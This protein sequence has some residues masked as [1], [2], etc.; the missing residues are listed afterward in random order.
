MLNPIFIIC[1]LSIFLTGCKSLEKPS[2]ISAGK[3][4]SNEKDCRTILTS[5]EE[6]DLVRYASQLSR[7]VFEQG[8][9]PDK[10]NNLLSGRLNQYSGLKR[11]A[12]KLS[13]AKGQE[14][15]ASSYVLSLV[16]SGRSPTDRDKRAL[17]AMNISSEQ[18]ESY[19]GA[20]SGIVRPHLN[21]F[22]DAGYKFDEQL[23]WRFFS[24]DQGIL[25][26]DFEE[27]SKNTRLLASFY[28]FFGPSI[29]S[30][31]LDPDRAASMTIDRYVFSPFH[32]GKMTVRPK[33]KWNSQVKWKLDFFEKESESFVK[34]AKAVGSYS[35]LMTGRLIELFGGERGYQG[36]TGVEISLESNYQKLR[37]VVNSLVFD[38]GVHED[39][40]VT[41]RLCLQALN[42]FELKQLKNGEKKLVAAQRAAVASFFVP[43][44]VWVSPYVAGFS[45][46]NAAASVAAATSAKLALLPMAFGLGSGAISAG[47]RAA[48]L[49]GGFSCQLYEQFSHVGP[50]ALIA[51]PFIAAIPM[52]LAGGS[53]GISAASLGTVSVST[54]YG[55]LNVGMATGLVSLMTASGVKGA[56]ACYAHAAL[57]EQAAYSG[58]QDRARL[59]IEKTYQSCAKAGIDLSF[60]VVSGT[61]MSRSAYQA[62]IQKTW[63]GPVAKP[64]RGLG[65]VSGGCSPPFAKEKVLSPDELSA[66]MK[67]PTRLHENIRTAERL[68]VIRN[69]P[70]GKINSAPGH[71]LL[72]NPAMVKSL[73]QK[74][75]ASSDRGAAL[76][77]NS[78]PIVVNVYTNSKAQ[79]KAVELIDGNHRFAAGLYAESLKPGSGWKTVADIP[80]NLLKVRVNGYDT[81]GYQMPRWVPLD[82]VKQSQIPQNQ[83]RVIPPEWGAKGPTAEISSAISSISTRFRPE[84]R[85]QTMDYVLRVTL[86]RL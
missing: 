31:L 5:A 51:A 24:A 41:M 36:K 54:T 11:K 32:K 33:K 81:H 78:D 37:E 68:D 64:C 27:L 18:V 9:S 85:G 73:G 7:A 49:G 39:M 40:Q 75:S 22:N 15:A 1:F 44:V 71:T 82:L 12:A 74:I 26:I 34:N 10:K 58:D 2:A 50:Q 16:S 45:L 84:H 65:L 80:A 55:T 23:G 72:R 13:I 79:V 19:L 25:E 21:A 70:V 35:N 46:G 53:V 6:L 76:L 67:K 4:S 17:A 86:D 52:S 28:F 66:Y 43:A 29:T 59:E 14:A 48:N 30:Q 38:Y 3:V 61:M 56:K 57:A 20:V 47:I 69:L 63:K 42:N 83:Y 62:M 77:K 8:Q 60:A